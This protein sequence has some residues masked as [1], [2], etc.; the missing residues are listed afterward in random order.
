MMESGL[1]S[2]EKI[3]PEDREKLKSGMPLTALAK[4]YYAEIVED[5]SGPHWLD[6]DWTTI[7]A[8]L[9]HEQQ[10]LERSNETKETYPFT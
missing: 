8:F 1:Y 10:A 7:S 5:R 4:R 9:H 3:T 2:V 6:S